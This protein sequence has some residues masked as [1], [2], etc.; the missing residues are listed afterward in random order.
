ETQLWHLANIGAD[1][2]Y[3]VRLDGQRFRVLA[4]DGNPVVRTYTAASLVMPPGKRYDVL[5]TGGP[6]GEHVL[7]T[8]AY[9]QGGDHYPDR[10]LATADSTG[11]VEAAQAPPFFF[12]PTPDL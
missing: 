5:V 9:D 4:Q 12:V 10:V 3:R 11:S 1:I 7:R 2:F 6:A 8:L